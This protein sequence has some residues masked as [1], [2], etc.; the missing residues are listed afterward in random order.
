[1]FLI[2][3]FNLPPYFTPLNLHL[4]STPLFCP[5]F[6][7]YPNLTSSSTS[8][9]YHFNYVSYIPLNLP[10][11]LF[12]L[13]YPLRP[14]LKRIS[15]YIIFSSRYLCLFLYCSWKNTKTNEHEHLKKN[16]NTNKHEHVRSPPGPKCNCDSRHSFEAH[17]R[18]FQS[19]PNHAIVT[20][21]FI[22][23]TMKVHQICENTPSPY[24]ISALAWV[25]GSAWQRLFAEAS[26]W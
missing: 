9:I 11:Y 3:S 15:N 17:C 10:T 5:F 22:R 12:P 23:K 6:F 4:F 16:T 19:N 25:P 8:L 20:G 26:T 13:I 21:T 1:M 18:K 7:T 14:F 2:N 24:L